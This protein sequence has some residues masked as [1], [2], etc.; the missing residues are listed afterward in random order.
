MLI[1][2]GGEDFIMTY[3]EEVVGDERLELRGEQIQMVRK[4]K[5]ND[6]REVLMAMALMGALILGQL[7]VK[8]TD[9]QDAGAITESAVLKVGET[10]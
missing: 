4:Q 2:E 1:W 10:N 8:L 3:F 5:M 6:E 7:Q 9:N